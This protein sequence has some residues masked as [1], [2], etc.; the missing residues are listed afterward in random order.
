MSL[1][2]SI[3]CNLSEDESEISGI[4]GE[5]DDKEKKREKESSPVA[6]VLP[7]KSDSPLDEGEVQ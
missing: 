4:N 7:H 6:S 5:D 3:D 1:N 2:I